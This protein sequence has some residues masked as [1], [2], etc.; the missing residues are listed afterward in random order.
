MAKT[1]DH[2]IVG[3]DVGGTKTLAA[4][5]LWSE[6][7]VPGRDVLQ[8]LPFATPPKFAMDDW[9]ETPED[10]A[11]ALRDLATSGSSASEIALGFAAD[12]LSPW[13]AVEAR[14]KS[15]RGLID[16]RRLGCQAKR[17]SLAALLNKRTASTKTGRSKDF[18]CLLITAR[19]SLVASM[20]SALPKR[21]SN[22]PRRYSTT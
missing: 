20:P 7:L 18:A 2:Y 5:R 19:C 11:P 15:K 10:V 13:N 22:K 4:V 14:Y 3:V 17:D 1:A 21:I 12:A 16:G 9:A 8:L 6:S